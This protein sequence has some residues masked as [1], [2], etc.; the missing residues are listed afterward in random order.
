MIYDFQCTNCSEK[1]TIQAKI[2]DDPKP[3]CPSCGGETRKLFSPPEIRFNG[4]G[5]YSTDK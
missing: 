2:T 5:F 3:E 1:L 4:K